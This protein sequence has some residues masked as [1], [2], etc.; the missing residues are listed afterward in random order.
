MSFRRVSFLMVKILVWFDIYVFEGRG[1]EQ[2]N[3]NPQ[4]KKFSIY[5]L[6]KILRMHF[7]SPVQFFSQ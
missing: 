6:T 3:Q 5:G 2:G 7:K 4:H 1:Y